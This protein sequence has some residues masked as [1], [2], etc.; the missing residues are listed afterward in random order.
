MPKAI[1]LLLG[2][3][4]AV[5]RATWERATAAVDYFDDLAPAAR[6]SA[7]TRYRA[8]AAYGRW[9]AFVL[10]RFPEVLQQ[11]PAERVDAVR[12]RVYVE[13][14][15]TRITAIGIASEIGYLIL[16]LSVLAPRERWTW[17]RRWQYRYQKRA[18]AREKRHKMVHP[19][20]LLELG[21]ALMDRAGAEARGGEQARQYRDGLLIALLATRPLRRRSLSELKIGTHLRQVGDSY[22]L[23]L[24]GVNTKSGY[25]VEFPLPELLTPYMTR[26]LDQYRLRFPKAGDEQALWLSAKGGALSSD[27]IYTRICRRTKDAFGFAI[28]P[29]LFR[30]IAATTI[31]REAPQALTV[32]RD[33]LT[34][35]NVQTTLRH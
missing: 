27:A 25:P 19:V 21:L 30:D 8:Q 20:Q 7:E 18:I 15:A 32:A 2:A 10:D 1:R 24:Q 3:W 9:L 29:H 11:P 14:L 34:H 17:L 22:V 12:A 26:Y 5:D 6:W 13:T 28:H 23:A 33:L 4:P 16:M 35:A 31:A